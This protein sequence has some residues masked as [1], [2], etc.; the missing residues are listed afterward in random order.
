MQEGKNWSCPDPVSLTV[1]EGASTAQN[2]G[3]DSIQVVDEDVE[4]T[5]YLVMSYS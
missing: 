1:F 5:M 2:L 4:V 3:A